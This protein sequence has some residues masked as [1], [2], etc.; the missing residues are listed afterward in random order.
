MM[1]RF[2]FRNLRG[3]RALV[4]IAVVLTFLDVGSSILGAFPL[5]FMLDKIVHHQD[6]N[7]GFLDGFLGRFDQIGTRNA[8]NNSEVHTQLGVIAFALTMLIALGLIGAGVAYAQQFIAAFVGTRLSARLRKRVFDHIQHLPLH[9]HERQRTGDIVNRITSNVT[10]VEKLVTDGLEDLLAGILILIGIV[11][12]VFLLN[13]QFAL[14]TMFIMPIL[15]GLILLYTKAIKRASKKASKLAGQVSEIA[16]ED[17]SAI[18]EVKTFTLEKRNAA[19]FGRYV[20][21]QRAAAFRAG[22]MDAEF[23]PQVAILIAASQ[24]FIISVGSWIAAGHGHTF[25]FGVL[26]VPEG[27]ITV[28]ALTVF[29]TYSKLLYQPMRGLSKLAYLFSN[30]AAGAERIQEVLDAPIE[31]MGHTATYDGPRRLQGHV[32]YHNVNF[33]YIEGIQVLKNI[34]LDIPAGKR[35]AL[36]GLSGSGKTTLVKLMPRFYEVWSGALTVDGVDVN[37]YPLPVLRD[38]ISMVLQDSVLFEGTIRENITLGRPDAT[39]EEMVDAAKKAQIHETILQIPDGYDAHVREQGKNFS[40]GQ[41]QRIAIARAI[42]R[43]APILVLDE[44]TANLDVEA[45]AEVMRAIDNLVTGRTVIMI[46]HRLSALGHVD[47]IVVMRDGRLVESGTYS[48][49]KNAGGEFARLLNEQYRYAAEKQEEFA[50]QLSSTSVEGDGRPRDGGDNGRRDSGASATSPV[51]LRGNGDGERS[52]S[53]APAGRLSQDL[54]N[55]MRREVAQL[56]GA[57]LSLGDDVGGMVDP[58]AEGDSAGGDHGHQ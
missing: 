2:L 28:G 56:E 14:M 13:W 15:F 32:R 30:A 52:P 8:L 19:H 10:D 6:P 36:V 43:D 27:T 21:R 33:G 38:N 26:T 25:G 51:A 42:L 53:K 31:E 9:W 34:Y 41:R 57:D 50:L 47:E 23:S 54:R 29:L 16:V 40:A 35:I 5:K 58:H 11:I 45:E 3:Y 1:T 55:A 39:E 4:V 48:E 20:D 37:D 44:P 22:R 49:L 12:V 17:I 46:S 24:A 18:T 7:V